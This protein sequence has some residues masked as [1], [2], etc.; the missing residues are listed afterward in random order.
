M[1]SA[2]RPTKSHGASPGHL[3]RRLLPW[4]VAIGILGYLFATTPLN[5]IRDAVA[6]TSLPLLILVATVYTVALLSAD[7]F[8]MWIG[9]R[10]AIPATPLRFG[11]VLVIRGASYLLAILSYSAGQGGIIYFLKRYHGI[12]LGPAAGAVL[13]TTGAF[14]IVLALLVGGGM[15]AGAVPERAELHLVAGA[16]V[17]SVPAYLVLVALRPRFLT[18]WSLLRPLFDAGVGGTL[19]VAGGRLLHATALVLGHWTV[20]RLFGVEVPLLDATVR[21]PVL[22]LVAALPISPAGLGTTQAAAITLFAS[23]APDATAAARHARVLAYSLSLQFISTLVV[24][25]IGL[26]FL[27][28]LTGSADPRGSLE[29]AA[30]AL[31]QGDQ[32]DPPDRSAA[33]SSGPGFDTTERDS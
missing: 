31:D 22:F 2:A 23:Y 11:A 26:Y 4:A 16:V 30:A 29:S 24:A 32:P 3:L 21:L 9:F 19:R 25:L 33:G 7:S 17:A 5:D 6:R 10:E 18:R 27:R 12:K 14:V 28:R 1:G 15:L 8:S 20:L 13:L